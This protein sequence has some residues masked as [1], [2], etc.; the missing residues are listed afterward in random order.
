MAMRARER[1]SYE[2]EETE[3]GWQLRM[4]EGDVEVGGG[5]GGPDDYAFLLATA[6]EFCGISDNCR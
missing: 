2:I 5:A 1:R 3:D 4:Y 6:E